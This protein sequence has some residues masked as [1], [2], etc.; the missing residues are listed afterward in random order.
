MKPIEKGAAQGVEEAD[1]RSAEMEA[2][3]RICRY[4]HV[5]NS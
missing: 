5:R 3:E 4:R 1:L 2:S